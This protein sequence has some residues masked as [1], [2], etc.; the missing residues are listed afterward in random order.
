MFKPP[1]C[2]Y[3]NCRASDPAKPF[4][5]NNFGRYRRKCDGRWI[6]R[7]RC[8]SCRRT[9]S[10]QTFKA[11]FRHH[12]P[13]LNY[14]LARLLASKVTRR[15]AAR[16]L[17]VNRKTVERR[18]HLLARVAKD[19]HFQALDNRMEEGGLPGIWQLDELETFETDRRLKPVTLAVTIE[20][21]SYFLMS[22]YAGRM[23]ARGNLTEAHKRKKERLEKIHGKRRSQSRAVVRKSFETLR[24]YRRPTLL[25]M[26]TD[27][28]KMYPQELDKVFGQGRYLHDTVSSKAKRNY[29]NLLFPINHTLAMMRGGLSCLVRR[30]WGAAKE[31]R[32]LQAHCWIWMAWRNYIRGITVRTRTTPAMGV[33][34]CSEAQ[35]WA[36]VFRWRWPRGVRG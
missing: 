8:H 6:P 23:A 7:F 2:T 24:M 29:Q 33:G 17:G 4:P 25:T 21:S 34:V 18:F 22:A 13:F 1:Y 32:G 35:S 14:R 30:S 27:R 3:R 10:K 20:R 16:M 5:Y 26:Q 11:N 36:S 31:M 19:F 12:I 15:Q 9:F 28:K